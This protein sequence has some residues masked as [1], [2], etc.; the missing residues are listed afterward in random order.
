[1]EIRSVDPDDLDAVRDLWTRAF[2]PRKRGDAWRSFVLRA[3]AENRML[4]VYEGARLTATGF[5]H[6]FEQWWHGRAVPMGGVAGVCVALG[7]TIVDLLARTAAEIRAGEDPVLDLT[8]HRDE[9]AAGSGGV[10]LAA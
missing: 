7:L 1:M 10:Q 4:G 9:V 8:T 3:I 5:F 2:G 6:A